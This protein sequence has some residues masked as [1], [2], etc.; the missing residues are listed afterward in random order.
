M[1]WIFWFLD[2]SVCFTCITT[3]IRTRPHTVNCLSNWFLFRINIRINRNSSKWI[4]TYLSFRLT[5][6]CASLVLQFAIEMTCSDDNDNQ[7]SIE[8]S[9]REQ[10]TPTRAQL[11]PKQSIEV[12]NKYMR[13][14][15][16]LDQMKRWPR[17]PFPSLITI[18]YSSSVLSQHLYRIRYFFRW[19]FRKRNP[20]NLFSLVQNKIKMSCY[21]LDWATVM[22]I[23]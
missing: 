13:Y 12:L 19:K 8:E 22:H 11:S 14:Y 3:H 4:F 6:A 16:H 17:K 5:T 21:R 2:K 15:L 7:T 1:H 18:F 10:S 9:Y 20:K 23:W